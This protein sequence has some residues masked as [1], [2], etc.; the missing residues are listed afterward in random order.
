MLYSLF[1]VECFFR[2][3]SVCL[4]LA[5]GQVIEILEHALQAVSA[6]ALF[7]SEE[8]SIIRT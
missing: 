2:W 5:P 1:D 6:L 4:R 8:T 7:P 3:W